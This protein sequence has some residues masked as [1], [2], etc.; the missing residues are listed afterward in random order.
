MARNSPPAPGYSW[1]YLVEA[2]PFAV[3][4]RCAAIVALDLTKPS[5]LR[6]GGIARHDEWHR[7]LNSAKLR[8]VDR[9]D[10]VPEG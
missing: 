7:G 3:C 1:P 8:L 9:P 5:D 2:L 6:G 4:D 10:H